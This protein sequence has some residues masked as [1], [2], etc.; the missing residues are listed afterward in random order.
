MSGIAP[1]AT[2]AR[3]KVSSMAKGKQPQ[4]DPP[5]DD[6]G[7]SS[8]RPSIGR[9]VNIRIPPDLDGRLQ[10]IA[11]VL[12]LDISNLVR[13][14]LNEQLHTYE[15]RARQIVESRAQAQGKRPSQ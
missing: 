10:F 6:K 14:V 5:A 4:N 13:L 12:G 15:A 1:P 8:G 3:R 11:D 7:R 9:Q 2:L